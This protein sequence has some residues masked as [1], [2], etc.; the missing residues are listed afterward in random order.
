MPCA[1]QI[2]LDPDELRYF[3]LDN[4]QVKWKCVYD[5]SRD[6]LATFL[7]AVTANMETFQRKLIIFRPDERLTLAIYVRKK[8]ERGRDNLVD[9]S[10]RLFAFPHT[11]ERERQSRLV[12]PTKMTYRLYCDDNIMQLFQKQRV[13]SWVFLARPG[14]D[15][16]QYRTIDDAGDRRRKIQST[17]DQK[18]N[19]DTRASVAL[20]KFSK[21]LQ[22][23]VGRVNRSAVSAAEIYIIS[24]RDV[25]SMQALD[26][27]LEYIATR[28]K[29]S[30]FSQEPKEYAI[31]KVEDVLPSSAPESI[32]QLIR[33]QDLE[34]LVLLDSVDDYTLAFTLMLTLDHKTFL[35]ACFDHL[36]Q[37][38]E[39]IGVD[40]RPVLHTMVKFLAKAPFLAISFGRPWQGNFSEDVLAV[41]EVS[42]IPIL[43]AFILSATS[44]GILVVESLKTTL[45]SIPDS[46]VSVSEFVQI[47]ELVSLTARS[48]EIAMDVLLECLENESGR[49]LS[50][51]SGT[52]RQTV[53]DLIGIA[54][55]HIAEASEEA[56]QR[57]DLF[58]LKFVSK[59]DEGCTT[60]D[61]AFR[62]DAP[63]GTPENSSHLRLTVATIPANAHTG[64]R[65]SIDGLVTR[66]QQG[67]V[68]VR[69]LHPLPPYFEQ[70]SW[71]IENC[72]PF[73]TAKT[74]FDA[75]CTLATEREQCCGIADL[76][77]D[78]SAPSS[79]LDNGDTDTQNWHPLGKLNAS[80]NVAIK[81]ALESPLVLLWGP[82]GTGKTETIVEMI[83]ALQETC[84]DA[85]ILVTAP[86]HNATDNVLRRYC[87]R[88]TEQPLQ[89]VTQ[90][91]PLRVSTD[92]STDFS[93]EDADAL[94][95]SETNVTLSADSEGCPGFTLI[96]M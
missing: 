88:L 57:E 29:M 59:D 28:D 46:S 70:C 65:Y 40:P 5:S 50:G 42:I 3:N 93:S 61:V 36:L 75:V 94:F 4:S 9:D 67:S 41:L 91:N 45:S 23:H 10:V 68:R 2:C 15:D 90:P 73:V 18:I 14:S 47:A 39:V 16:S 24:N 89:T 72:G 31:P 1:L 87:R 49:I 11:Q 81:A 20:D 32:V 60:V 12:L 83:R 63:G 69:C 34:A 55:D 64:G 96:H 95:G 85:R 77:L 51:P 92:V 25:S 54:L 26:L 74:T 82:P 76:L 84:H 80:Q 53:R 43:R 79:P 66:S 38:P 8:L 17:V 44:A 6:R 71:R 78:L 37:N 62:I 58:E 56:R 52:I 19:F 22:R 86:T 21:G 30:L 27:W 7:E 13:N 33:Q 35:L 48:P